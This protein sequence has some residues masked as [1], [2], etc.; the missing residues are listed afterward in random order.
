MIAHRLLR[1]ASRIPGVASDLADWYEEAGRVADEARRQRLED[2]ARDE[3]DKQDMARWL[4]EP[5]RRRPRPGVSH[6]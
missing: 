2:E 1:L 4:R 6:E 3:R 5:D